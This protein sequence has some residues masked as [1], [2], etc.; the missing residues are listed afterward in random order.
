MVLFKTV[1][2][3]GKLGDGRHDG[4]FRVKTTLKTS[5]VQNYTQNEWGETT[6][7]TSE[8]KTTLKTSEVFSHYIQEGTRFSKFPDLLSMCEESRIMITEKNDITELNKQIELRELVA[9]SRI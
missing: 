1:K 9:Y 7:K 2:I 6:L 3:R 8:A 5:E 4:T